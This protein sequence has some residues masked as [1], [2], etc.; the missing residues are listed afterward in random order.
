MALLRDHKEEELEKVS[1]VVQEARQEE[2][3]RLKV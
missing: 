1:Q 3:R 2:F